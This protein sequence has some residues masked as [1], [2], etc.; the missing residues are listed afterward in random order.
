MKIGDL[1]MK[2]AGRDAGKVGVVVEIVDD[3]YVILDGQ[4]RKR[5]CNIRHLEPLGKIL[6]IKEKTSSEDLA[7]ILEKEGYPV[8]FKKTKK[9]F[10][11]QTKK[12]V[13]KSEENKAKKVKKVVKK[14]KKND[15]K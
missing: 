3:L 15:K 13:L 9:A 8:I 5:K 7:K 4:V 10:S 14:V 11:R 2:I 1:C 12:R 6:K